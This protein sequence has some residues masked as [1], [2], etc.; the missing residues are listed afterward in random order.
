VFIIIN[1]LIWLAL[2]IIIGVNAH[3]A[4]PVSPEFKWI[5]AILSIVMAGILMC[6]FIFL[7]RGSRIAFYLMVVLLGFVTFLTIFDDVGLSDIIVLV[8]NLI[9]VI[10][11]IKDRKWYFKV[12][13]QPNI[14][15]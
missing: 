10:L 6:L 4:L 2:G 3:P 13:S 12:G 11:L 1:A 14:S 15:V 5:M 9:P 7:H 8:L